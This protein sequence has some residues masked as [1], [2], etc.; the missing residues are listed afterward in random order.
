MMLPDQRLIAGGMFPGPLG[1]GAFAAVKFC[2]YALAGVVLRKL[3]P[4]IVA[5][6]AKIAAVRTALGVAIGPVLLLLFAGLAAAVHWDSNSNVVP[7]LV[8][9]FIRVLVWALVIWIFLRNTAESRRYLWVN[10]GV[11]AIWSCLLDLPAFFLLNI[12]PGKI[13][14]C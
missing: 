1:L 2:G 10:A 6:P 13:P 3:Y 5:A 11:G 12:A 7:Y 4:A 8:L 14:I 9:A